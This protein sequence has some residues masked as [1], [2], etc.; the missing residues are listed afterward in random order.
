MNIVIFSPVL[1]A[2][3]GSPIRAFNIIKGLSRYGGNNNISLVSSAFA[4]ELL[5]NYKCYSVADYGIENTLK[6]AVEQSQADVL[7]CITHSS[8]NIVRKVAKSFKIPFFVDIHGISTIEILEERISLSEKLKKIYKCLPWFLS[9][10]QA[11]KI[12]CASPTLYIWMR[13]L[14]G[15]RAI[16]LSGITDV[17]NFKYTHQKNK[18][19]KISYAG[20]LRHYQGVDMLLDAINIIGN[21]DDFKFYILGDIGINE[22]LKQKI[23]SMRKQKN[24]MIIPSIDYTKYPDFLISMDVFV[25][26]RRSSLTT[27]MAFPQKLIEAMSAG[28]CVIAT[29]LPSHRIALANPVCGILCEPNPH[30]LAAAIIRAKDSNLRKNLGN[31][32]RTKAL[33]DYDLPIQISK[34]IHF[35]NSSLN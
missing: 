28:K 17:S 1:R 34:I 6:I 23:E 14:F 11:N 13:R 15:N 12:F 25:I 3:T 31:A 24:L 16:D 32:A 4:E 33:K 26:P 18:C 19:V 5:N 35:L 9:I 27:Y 21:T 20:N 22:F 29:N 8:A 30:S 2:T 7:F 10:T